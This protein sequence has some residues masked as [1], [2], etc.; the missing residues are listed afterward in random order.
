MSAPPP[1]VVHDFVAILRHHGV[2]TTVQALSGRYGLSGREIGFSTLARMARDMGF[3]ATRKRLAPRRLLELGDAYPALAAT[4]DGGTV[5]LSGVR[6]AGDGDPELVLYDLTRGQAGSPFVF[7]SGSRLADRFTGEVLLLRKRLLDEGD[8]KR[9]SLGWFL[10]QVGREKRIFFEIACIAFFMHGL[11][12]AVPLYFQNVV[13]KVL[14]HHVLSTLNVLGIGVTAAIVFEGTLR[15]LREYLLRYATS[16]IDLRLA[17]ETFAHMVRLP[18]A[19]FE[20]SFAGVIIKHMQQTDQ[21]REFLTGNLLNALL[22]ASSLLVFLPVLF[23]Y[24]TQLTMIVLVFAVVTAGIIA[25][26][27]GPFQRRLTS[28][29]AAEG[30]RQ[31]LL[32]ETIHGMGTIKS[33]ALE[34]DRQRRWEEGSAA[35]V[36]R[37]FSVRTMSAAG[38][39]L[40]KTLERLLTVAVIFFGAR[41]VFDGSLTVGELIAFQML[42]QSVTMPLIRIVELIHEYQRVHLAVAMLGEVMNKKP[43]PGLA[44]GGS[45]PEIAG[46]I[47]IED[48]RFA[49]VPGDPPA[50]DGVSLRIA[51]GEVLG[52]VGKSGSGKTTLTRLIQGLYP[53]SQGRILFDGASIRDMDIVHLR[54]N[55]GV[56]LQENF[57][58]HGPL[59]DNLALTRPDADFED[60][61][62]AARLAGADEFIERLPSGYDTILEENGANL[63]GGQRQ[64]LAIARA[65]LKDPRIMIFDEATSALDPDSESRIQENMEAISTGRTTIIVAHRLSTLRHADRIMV[66]DAGKIADIGPHSE[67]LERCDIYRNL[68]DKQ[69]RGMR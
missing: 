50:L 62:R 8:A 57:I 41:G 68:W 1:K 34:G 3:A 11:A 67:L 31:A 35:A 6:K 22:D 52:V 38:Q 63:S 59:K 54:Q 58:F 13:D 40:I 42:S 28:L 61:R 29:Y 4:R 51:P 64:R 23:L 2:T 46:E 30:R 10:P 45:R 65:L 9:F 37:N 18:L 60:L 43:E 19:F 25:L 7:V 53:L 27:I 66:L 56:V 21:V 39:S 44:K 32:V 24:S 12:F 49:Y 16:R 33:L 17:M 15:F 36:R 55:I 20:R 5:M 26:M 47:V 69:T 48:V 14:A